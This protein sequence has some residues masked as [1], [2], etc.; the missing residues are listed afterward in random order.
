M[1]RISGVDGEIDYHLL[2]LPRIRIHQVQQIAEGDDEL[3]V[4]ADQA[5]QHLLETGDD[6]VDADRSGVH[7]L[8]A[9]ECEQLSS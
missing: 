2:Q 4:F 1:H 5:P 7:H 9:T 8:L 3:D 6:G